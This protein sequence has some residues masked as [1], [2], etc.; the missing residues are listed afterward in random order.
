MAIAFDAV[1]DHRVEGG[2]RQVG[3]E[4]NILRHEVHAELSG[5]G[6]CAGDFGDEPGMLAHL[7]DVAHLDVV[8]FRGRRRG[9]RAGEPT[10]ASARRVRM[11]SA[12]SFPPCLDGL[13]GRTRS[14]QS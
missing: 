9:D 5:F 13:S 12:S 3:V 1:A 4:L 2:E 8:G 6:L 11:I 7:V 10:N 14:C